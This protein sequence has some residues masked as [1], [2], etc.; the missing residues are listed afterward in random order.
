MHYF[1]SGA[2]SMTDYV[3]TSTGA[4]KF[5]WAGEGYSAFAAC[6]ASAVSMT[7]S[8]INLQ[9]ERVYMY[10]ISKNMTETNRTAPPSTDLTMRPTASPSMMPT[11]EPIP[12]SHI[13]ETLGTPKWVVGLAS[14]VILGLGACSCMYGHYLY[15]RKEKEEG[16]S[17]S[18]QTETNNDDIEAAEAHKVIAHA[19]SGVVSPSKPFYALAGINHGARRARHRR[20]AARQEA[21][22]PPAAE[23]SSPSAV[24][25][26]TAGRNSH[27]TKSKGGSM[28]GS[29]VPSSRRY[30]RTPS[31]DFREADD[32]NYSAYTV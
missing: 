23:P 27:M 4:Q 26:N 32:D 22:S 25:V 16:N 3:S 19:S 31:R 18:D 6:R 30:T 2:G 9:S 7:V 17:L 15:R 8:F 24:S 5:Y 29:L 21:F 1:V 13:D 20:H 10:T 28:R 12:D 14:S 11:A